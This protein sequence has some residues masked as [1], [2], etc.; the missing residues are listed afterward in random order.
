MQFRH[1]F[2]AKH[3]STQSLAYLPPAFQKGGSDTRSPFDGEGPG[4]LHARLERRRAVAETGL[5]WESSPLPSSSADPRD[6]RQ[7]AY[8]CMMEEWRTE[9]MHVPQHQVRRARGGSLHVEDF[10]HFIAEV[11]L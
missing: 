11:E 10:T 3:W 8:M 7:M 9:K 5:Q 6:P 4:E 2:A 1:F